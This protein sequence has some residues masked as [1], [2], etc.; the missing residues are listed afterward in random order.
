[1]QPLT[2]ARAPPTSSQ[3]PH[4]G[5]FDALFGTMRVIKMDD[6]VAETEFVV[7]PH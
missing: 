2:L 4:K 5:G 3:L 6:G 7:R 1:V